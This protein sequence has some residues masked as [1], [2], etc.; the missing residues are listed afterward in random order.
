MLQDALII[1]RTL[2]ETILEVGRDHVAHVGPVLSFLGEVDHLL[3]HFSAGRQR[4]LVTIV[5]AA[6][7]RQRTELMEVVSLD[8]L[9]VVS[10]STLML[11]HLKTV[12]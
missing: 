8:E 5:L 10:S 9:L 3:V 4:I 6:R 1:E 2:P 12:D 7:A 11:L